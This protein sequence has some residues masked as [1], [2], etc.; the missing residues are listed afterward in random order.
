MPRGLSM[1]T[2]G[3]PVAA[4]SAA[5]RERPDRVNEAG[6]ARMSGRFAERNDR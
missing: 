2:H 5:R 3:I 6:P 1:P 4:S